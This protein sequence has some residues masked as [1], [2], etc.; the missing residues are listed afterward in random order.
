MEMNHYFDTTHPLRPYTHSLPANPGTI[1]PDNALRGEQ[2]SIKKGF[3]PCEKGGA[4]IDVEDH[5]ERTEAKGFPAGTEQEGVEY[6]LPGDTWQAPARKMES[7]GPLPDGWSAVKPEPSV[8]ELTAQRLAAIDARLAE[9]DTAST[10]PIRALLDGSGTEDDKERLAGLEQEAE[11]LR[12]ER[13]G[14]MG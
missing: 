8:E 10:R 5:R 4:W 14:L 11:A 1:P 12:E 6:W 9:I 2:P 13:K 7:I 3:W